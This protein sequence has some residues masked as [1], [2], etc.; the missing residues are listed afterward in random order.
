MQ[1]TT[2]GVRPK[3]QFEMRL[4]HRYAWRIGLVRE[5]LLCQ[6]LERAVVVLLQNMLWKSCGMKQWR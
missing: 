3:H 5:R 1:L 2:N 6:F 4:G